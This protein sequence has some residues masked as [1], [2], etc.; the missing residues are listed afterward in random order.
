MVIIIL[1]YKEKLKVKVSSLPFMR[2]ITKEP[3]A[4]ED[5]DTQPPQA[6]NVSADLTMNVAYHHPQNLI[7]ST[8]DTKQGSGL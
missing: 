1:Q 6:S 3:S 7:A 2:K 4:Y 8:C 5:V